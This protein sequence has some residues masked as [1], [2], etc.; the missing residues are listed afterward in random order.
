MKKFFTFFFAI[1]LVIQ[2]FA[3]PGLAETQITLSY[4]DYYTFGSAVTI[5]SSSVSADGTA[6]GDTNVIEIVDSAT[7]KI[8]AV[9]LGTASVTVGGTTYTITVNKADIALIMIAGQS[10]AAGDSSDYT[11]APK[12]LGDYEGKFYITNTMN[13]T[14]GVSE[15]NFEAATYTAQHGGRE[16]TL[17]APAFDKWSAA[18]ASSLA[19][20][21]V[22]LW[23]KK[24][25][26]VNAAVCGSTMRSW[27]DGGSL[28]ANFINYAN[29]AK[30]TINNNGHYVLDT[31]KFGYL[32]LQ[33]C[34][35]GVNMRNLTMSEYVN[36]FMSMHN[37]FKAQTGV[38]YAAIW[39]VR[40]GVYVD[41]GA[42]DFYMSGPRLAQYYLGN[43][44][45]TQYSDIYLLLN[46]D[47][48]RKDADVKTYFET[49]YTSADFSSRF[50]YTMPTTAAEIKPALH[51]SQKGYNEL[52]D[53]GAINLNKI[54]TNTASVTSAQLYDVNGNAFDGT[55]TVNRPGDTTTAV[56]VITSN[57]YNGSRGIT[58]RIANTSIAT[59]DNDKYLVTGVRRGTT[60]LDILDGSTV[61]A[62]YT[63]NVNEDPYAP[64]DVNSNF[65]LDF[66]SSSASRYMSELGMA[67]GNSTLDSDGLRTTNTASD[68]Y[69]PLNIG[70]RTS[71]KYIIET[72]LNISTSNGAQFLVYGSTGY[73][74]IF[75]VSGTTLLIQGASNPEAV[76]SITLG[77]DFTI[78]MV[79]DLDNNSFELYKDGIKLTLPYTQLFH[80]T[81]SGT[82]DITMV[83]WCSYANTVM[84]IK[85]VG[86][87]KC[88]DYS[89]DFSVDFTSKNAYNETLTNGMA[90]PSSVLLTDNGL[91]TT[92]TAATPE[93]Y[94]LNVGSRTSGKYIIQTT[95]K[96]LTSDG[97]QFLVFGSTGYQQI[98][99]IT[100]GN[101]LIQGASIPQLVTSLPTGQDF[102]LKMVFD[103]DNNSFEL[104]KNGTKLTLPYTQLFH[105]TASGTHDI[106][107]VKW[108]SYPNN[109]MYIKNCSLSQVKN[110]AGDF[111]F[112]FTSTSASN[113]VS[114][115]GI[116][117]GAATLTS[118]GIKVNSATTV[119]FPFA[120]R[121]SGKYVV[122]AEYLY[123]SGTGMQVSFNA[124]DGSA[125]QKMSVA[126][127]GTFYTADS[128][129]TPV[130]TS[131]KINAG[132]PFKV[133][134]VID[135][136]T[137]DIKAYMDGNLL[138]LP[139]DYLISTSANLQ[140]ITW[141]GF[142]DSCFYIKNIKLYSTT[143][144][145]VTVSSTATNG[146]TINIPNCKFFIGDKFNLST[147]VANG[148]TFNRWDAGTL[149]NLGS[150]LDN[151][152]VYT[153]NG[154]DTI[155]AQC[156]ETAKIRKGD[157]NSDGKIDIIDAIMIYEKLAGTRIFGNVE[158]NC[159]E[160]N[161]NSVLDISD[162]T[163]LMKYTARLIKTFDLTPAEI[164][165]NQS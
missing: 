27:I 42:S 1:L 131:A 91:L 73:Q 112:D 32:W 19:R 74:Q 60:T 106:T 126:S 161:G 117:L 92:N 124:E 148:Y 31:S 13:S 33:G 44:S 3:F 6:L 139:Y 137:K 59:V 78:K 25:W 84:H 99:Y 87:Y 56:P 142:A 96:S 52:G 57:N 152:T 118:N 97:A 83:K 128:S 72:T 95:I 107:M 20:K 151:S 75:Y 165:A 8:H 149:N 17:T 132:V 105:P 24:V 12:A 40:A 115:A 65:K 93:Y 100:G 53:E 113:D 21:L 162:A 109:R 111:D 43:S 145:Y 86:A 41:N 30:N 15:V 143:E 82:H 150:Y 38:N 164:A 103:L 135:C 153:V 35:D 48:W 68:E 123:E 29:T 138:D 129:G 157:I 120:T 58:M 154:P 64:I 49:K 156:V 130:A 55:V 114:N 39:E 11:T 37:K 4:D 69:Y 28:N 63:V 51:Y 144:E 88:T 80:P 158:N 89:K 70:T 90:L 66:T 61:L 141:T 67:N 7:G 122:E 125:I 62:T 71:G 18:A 134:L 76:S 81:A 14:L 155:S 116:D 85:N 50:G 36:S 104:Y 121:N 147:S 110:L 77:Q 47:I 101:L 5:N 146:S 2:L 23:G 79:L 163:K 108:C 102:T 54:L 140:K 16:R 26:V 45:D 34:S 46:T 98:F 127:D 22:D 160:L 10:N 119:S 159:A 133:K 94:T 9:G 136:A